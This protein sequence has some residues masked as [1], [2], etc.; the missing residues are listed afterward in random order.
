MT[1]TD[2]LI[3]ATLN[4]RNLAD[5]WR[6]RAPL[7]VEQ[8]V[9]LQPDIIGLQEI[10]RPGG[11]GNW[12]VHEV[13]R[14][15][16]SD[17]PR[18]TIVYAWKTGFRRFWEGLA[19]MTRLPVIDTARL[20]LDGGSRV[21]QRVRVQLTDGRQLAFYNTHL[22]HRA[23]D[24]ALRLS[25]AERIVDWME[26]AGDSP[27]VL[28]GD[29]NSEPDTDV[30]QMLSN[31]LRSAYRVANGSEPDL[32]APTPLNATE[33]SRFA[34]IDYVF[35]DPRLMLCEAWLTFDRPDPED[36]SL[37]ASDHFGIAARVSLH[38]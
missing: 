29:L 6:E 37:Y 32:T 16:P 21:A 2:S 5:R 30:V 20:D 28:V 31:R 4:V 36:S 8:L 7:L 27:S 25:Q 35:V 23:E 34:T 13:N 9:D 38:R 1:S 15:L 14:R 17:T 26:D 24:D 22:H 18:Y 12:I 3:V 11:Q 33:T 10:R 19:V